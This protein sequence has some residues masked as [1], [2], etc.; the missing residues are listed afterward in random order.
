MKNAKYSTDV[1]LSTKA[2]MSTELIVLKE[3]QEKSHSLL[4]QCSLYNSIEKDLFGNSEKLCFSTLLLE[5][6][7]PL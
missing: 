7:H 6:G 3:E 4:H 5:E 1:R 2:S